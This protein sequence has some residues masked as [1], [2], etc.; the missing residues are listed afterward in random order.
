MCPGA[1][2]KDPRSIPGAGRR[3]CVGTGGVD[4][5]STGIVSGRNAVVQRLSHI[6]IGRDHRCHH[7][8]SNTV[9]GKLHRLRSDHRRF[10]YIGKVQ[11]EIHTRIRCA[12]E[13]TGPRHSYRMSIIWRPTW[14][15]CR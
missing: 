8:P 2:S 5:E 9:L 6:W 15:W 14:D 11:R 13:A 7:A 4:G 1:G 3:R 12:A 10:V